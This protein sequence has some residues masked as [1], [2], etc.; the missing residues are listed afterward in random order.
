MNNNTDK[1]GDCPTWPKKCI[2]VKTG[3]NCC[4]IYQYILCMTSL[5]QTVP[6]W[7]QWIPIIGWE[8]CID[9][10]ANT[11]NARC[12]RQEMN[13]ILLACILNVFTSIL[14]LTRPSRK[15][16]LCSAFFLKNVTTYEAET[17]T[18]YFNKHLCSHGQHCPLS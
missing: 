10:C 8:L 17:S 6:H 5:D 11:R 18:G 1:K 3:F 7:G 16:R 15:H 12:T 14:L 9:C 13:I 2:Q 4:D